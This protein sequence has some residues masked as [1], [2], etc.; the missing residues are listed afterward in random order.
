MRVGVLRGGLVEG[1]GGV[2][3]VVL[4]AC[5]L[6]LVMVG[7]RREKVREGFG[8]IGSWVCGFGWGA[9]GGVS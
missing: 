7:L 9:G 3:K 2:V 1:L 6:K 8:S 4:L 5:V